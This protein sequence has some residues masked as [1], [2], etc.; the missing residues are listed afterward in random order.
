MQMRIY[1]ADS[2]IRIELC[3][4]YGAD[5]IVQIVIRILWYGLLCKFY[6]AYSI[7]Q[8]RLCKF[9][10][11]DYHA[12]F[13]VLVTSCGFHCADSIMQI[14]SCALYHLGFIMPI[15]SSDFIIYLQSY[16]F[17]HMSSIICLPSYV[18]H[19]LHSIVYFILCIPSCVFYL[20]CVFHYVNCIVDRPKKEEIYQDGDWYI[21]ALYLH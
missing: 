8:T 7:V 21:G 19:H 14:S 16:A 18:F 11:A 13:I 10:H 15:L 9:H 6:C 12:G 2:I 4:F 17:H 5:S 3:R 20:L 1:P